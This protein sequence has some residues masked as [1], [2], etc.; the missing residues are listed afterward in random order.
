[1]SAPA[2]FDGVIKAAEPAAAGDAHG[3]EAPEEPSTG[4]QRRPDGTMQ[5]AMRRWQVGR[6]AAS[7][8]PENRRHRS[9]TWSEDGACQ[10]DLHLR[11][12]GSRKDRGKDPHGTAKGDRPGEQGRPFGGSAHGMSLPIH[13]DANCDKWTKSS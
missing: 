2:A 8:D 7:H 1:M 3:H 6:C 10:E 13:C 11:P 12:H 5:D 9:L 4:V